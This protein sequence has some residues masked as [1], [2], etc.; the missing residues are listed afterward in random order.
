MLFDKVTKTMC[1]SGKDMLSRY[2]QPIGSSSVDA[3]EY[4]FS[5]NRMSYVDEYAFDWWS[6]DRFLAP[7]VLTAALFLFAAFTIVAAT[8]WFWQ[9]PWQGTRQIALCTLLGMA[10][11]LPV[12]ISLWIAL[13][14]QKWFIRIPL[15]TFC[16]SALL[17][18]YFLTMMAHMPQAVPPG[19]PF[20]VISGMIFFFYAA[21]Q[22]PLWVVRV[23]YGVWLS[24]LE[25]ESVAKKQFT[26]KQL[27][28]T[29]TIFAFLV[30]LIQWFSAFKI[31]ENF[32]GPPVDMVIGFC[33][34]IVV[35]LAF[36]TLL[37]VLIVF[38]SKLR[39]AGLCVL[40]LSLVAIPFVIVPSIDYAVGL[41]VSYTETYW[42][43]LNVDKH[44]NVLA[45]AL[46]N[47]VTMI[48]VLSMY[49]ALGFRLRQQQD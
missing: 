7:I 35:V 23:R 22:I 32:N 10:L 2:E 34:V 36:L 42:L 8:T 6:P 17:G 41:R 33:S 31:F 38:S 20:L 24:R 40:V 28:I 25:P 16:L 19:E 4:E 49:Y 12:L 44:I 21:I 9:M 13:G 26:I 11:S 47:A 1:E 43:D 46:S 45:F 39:M 14:A 29:T 27:L 48:V 3:G 18:I 37:S 30:P 15:A 5:K